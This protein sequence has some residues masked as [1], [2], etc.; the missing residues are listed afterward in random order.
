MIEA[1]TDDLNRIEELYKDCTLNLNE[2]GIYQ[3]DDRYPSISTYI[4]SIGNKCQYIFEADNT[5]IGSV[6]LNES[7]SAEWDLI[8][9]NYIEGKILVIHALAISPTVQGK[10]Y[11]QKVLELCEA[12]GINTGY[13]AMRLDV[14]SENQA[15]IRLYEK[16]GYQ[17][18]GEVTFSFRPEGHQKYYCYDK[19]LIRQ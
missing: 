10:G 18:V 13:T 3:W 2:R 7:Q 6:I 5:L 11:G 14:F 1:T 9:W 19:M 4:S 16:N 8:P 17:K 15:A 12:H